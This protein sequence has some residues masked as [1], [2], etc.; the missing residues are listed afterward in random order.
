MKDLEPNAS[1]LPD[2][3]GYKLL[4]AYPEVERAYKSGLLKADTTVHAEEVTSV[5]LFVLKVGPEA[6]KDQN[7]FPVGPWCK[8]GDFV[9]CRSYSGTRVKI[10]GKPYVLINDDMV[11]AVVE[12]PRGITRA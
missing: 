4:C 8:K 2:P 12:D 9:L 1:Q 3:V 7:K 10:H 6:Y 11:E 5:V